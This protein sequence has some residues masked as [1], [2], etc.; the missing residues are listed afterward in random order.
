[1]DVKDPC[2]GVA[3]ERQVVLDVSSM[4]LRQAQL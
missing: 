4:L 1:M 2:R 3:I